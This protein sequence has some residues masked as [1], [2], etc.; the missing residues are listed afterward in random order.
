L[1][2][3]DVEFETPWRWGAMQ[4][5]NVAQKRSSENV[6]LDWKEQNWTE[7]TWN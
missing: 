2:C 4:R 5:S 1:S 3:R 6:E 7:E